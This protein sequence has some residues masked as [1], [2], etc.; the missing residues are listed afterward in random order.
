MPV[1]EVLI[2][3]AVAR[4]HLHNLLELSP[5]RLGL[6]PRGR[7]EALR[8]GSWQDKLTMFIFHNH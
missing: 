6:L 4:Y 1:A 7:E 2:E 5:C 8:V 3:E